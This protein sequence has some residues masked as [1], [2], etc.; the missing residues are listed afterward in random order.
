MWRV[1]GLPH[2]LQE[3]PGRRPKRSHPPLSSTSLP[4][5]SV[6]T[7]AEATS[8]VVMQYHASIMA[9][10]TVLVDSLVRSSSSSSLRRSAVSAWAAWKL[11]SLLISVRLLLSGGRTACQA[12]QAPGMT[13]Q[14][15][16]VRDDRQDVHLRRFLEGQAHVQWEGHV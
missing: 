12:R 11:D 6:W 9:H 14:V 3:R 13:V 7:R 4:K 2:D 1:A 5:P 10:M 8:P 15:R 16:V